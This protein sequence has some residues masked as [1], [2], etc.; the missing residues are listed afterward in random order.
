MSSHRIGLLALQ[1][2]YEAHGKALERVG[3]PRCDI[4][5][6]RRFSDLE[7]LTALIIPGGES[8][9]MSMLLER[10]GMFDELKRR[11]VNGMPIL[12][13]CAGLILLAKDIVGNNQMSLGLLDIRVKRNAYGRQVDSFHAPVQ[14]IISSIGKIEGIF[15][16][17]P[18]ILASGKEVEVLAMYQDEPVMIRQGSIVAATFHPELL[19]DAPVHRW[20]IQTFI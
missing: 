1:G 14:T 11:I 4:V 2:D 17:A 15:I 10:F 20:F 19:P 7:S 16:R 13:T 8:T 6:V 5:E 12:A 9:V 3:F 18:R